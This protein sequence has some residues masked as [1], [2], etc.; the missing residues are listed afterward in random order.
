MFL[1]VL[2]MLSPQSSTTEQ[3]LHACRHGMDSDTGSLSTSTVAEPETCPQASGRDTEAILTF[4]TR[5]HGPVL[6]EAAAA[7]DWRARRPWCPGL[8][9]PG[10]TV[11][12]RAV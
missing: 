6:R 12:A 5:G 4:A 11:A 8:L 7:G 9:V 3:G 1:S 2:L 10:D